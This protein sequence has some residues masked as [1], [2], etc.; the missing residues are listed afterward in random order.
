M[1]KLPLTEH[2]IVIR[3]D[4]SN[5]KRWS[6]LQAVASAPADP[7]IFSIEVVDDVFFKGKTTEEILAS[8]PKEY[9][10]S[11]VFVADQQ[12]IRDE[13]YPC[14]VIDLLEE[15]G[16]SF[17]AFAREIASIENNLSIANMG[18]EEFAESVGEDG[19]F[20]GFE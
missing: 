18:F 12:A 17:R 3:T 10:H 7:F 2:A 4:F 9:P 1:K 6:Q 16:R 8:F 14:L 5:A 19:V 13:D 15:P 20:R 11:F